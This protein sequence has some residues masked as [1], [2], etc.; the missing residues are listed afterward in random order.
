MRHKKPIF[1]LITILLLVSIV[2]LLAAWQGP[3]AREKAAD[4]IAVIEK[5]VYSYEYK[6]FGVD[7][8]LIKK[9]IK[10]YNRS[11]RLTNHYLERKDSKVAKSSMYKYSVEELYEERTDASELIP[12]TEGVED[13]VT[14]GSNSLTGNTNNAEEKEDEKVYAGKIVRKEQLNKDGKLEYRYIYRYDE[15]GNRYED[16]KLNS[17]NGQIWKYLMRHNSKGLPIETRE[18]DSENNIIMRISYQYNSKGQLIEKGYFD[19][20]GLPL[21]KI[22]YIR[23]MKGKLKQKQVMTYANESFKFQAAELYQYGENGETNR[24]I[25]YTHGHVK[26]W[27]KVLEY[28]DDGKLKKESFYDIEHR[29]GKR[30]KVL[31]TVG[32]YSYSYF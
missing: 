18:Y 3:A 25:G 23:D 10:H 17:T 30:Y 9:E 21:S 11:N 24:I 22:S 12:G 26:D 4:G 8:S 20:F 19:F 5:S 2:S 13:E 28:Y 16:S 14:N 32:E 7:K 6:F 1:K 29:E 27:E 15:K 31:K